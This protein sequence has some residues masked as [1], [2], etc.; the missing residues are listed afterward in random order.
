MGAVG[1]YDP[2]DDE[3]DY[4]DDDLKDAKPALPRRVPSQGRR[5]VR[6]D[7]RRAAESVDAGDLG[8]ALKIMAE[9][10]AVQEAEPK[11][12]MDHA[13]VVE[14]FAERHG[15]HPQSVLG[16]PE[17]G[18]VVVK[19]APGERHDHDTL[20]K[21]NAALKASGLTGEQ[22]FDGINQILNAGILFRERTIGTVLH[23]AAE[24][25]AEDEVGDKYAGA[26]PEKAVAKPTF[27]E[28]MVKVVPYHAFVKSSMFSW[29]AKW[30]MPNGVWSVLLETKILQSPSVK[31]D[32]PGMNTRMWGADSQK[33][34]GMLRLMGA[35]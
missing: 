21:V 16:G 9:V 27:V 19:V 15:E 22:A 31:V 33:V 4:E 17:R 20:D 10:T 12:W 23:E 13:E 25:M 7:I 8:D 32:G 3:L 11:V 34:I 28:E 2:D 35:L 26:E 14:K 5:T 24:A 29:Q 6:E 1:G 30:S 18:E